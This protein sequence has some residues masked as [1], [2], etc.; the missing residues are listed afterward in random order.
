MGDF[1]IDEINK[2]IKVW[3]TTKHQDSIKAS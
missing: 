2:A 3:T 1:G